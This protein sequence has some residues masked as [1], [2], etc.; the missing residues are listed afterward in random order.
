MAKGTNQIGNLAVG[1]VSRATSGE[2]QL[3]VQDE[4]LCQL[5]AGGAWRRLDTER[6]CGCDAATRELGNELILL[7]GYFL[8]EESARMP[9]SW[10]STPP[11]SCRTSAGTCEVQPKTEL[12]WAYARIAQLEGWADLAMAEIERLSGASEE[13][14]RLRRSR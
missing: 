13:A 3:S 8:G 4:P 1:S 10:P 6:G 2:N 5:P 9:R 7:T 12:E 11:R 14:E